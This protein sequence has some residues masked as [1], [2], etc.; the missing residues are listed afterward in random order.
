MS[1]RNTQPLMLAPRGLSDALD[2]STVFSGAMAALENLIPDPSTRNLWQCRPAA[3]QLV[4]FNSVGGPFSSGFSS[5]FATGLFVSPVGAVSVMKVVGNFAYGMVASATG[6]DEPFAFNL[7][8]HTFAVVS[9]T[10]ASN[11]PTSPPPTGA[12]VPP[13]M[14]LIGTKIMV[15][16]PGFNGSVNGF[17]GMLDISV[18][19]TPVWSSG[20]LTGAVTF[21]IPPTAVANFNGRA[22]WIENG[23]Q[24]GLIFSDQLAPTVVTLANQVLTFD[25]NVPLTALAGLGVGMEV[26]GAVLQ[27]LIVFKGASAMYQ[28]TGDAAEQL[29]STLTKNAL[30]VPIGTL[31]PNTI[32][33][34]SKGLMFAAPDGLRMID[35]QS[36]VSDPI[37]VDGMG[38]VL[39]FIYSNVP[40]RMCAAANG[41]VYRITMQDSSISGSPFVEYWYD[42]PRQ[43]WS[44]PHSFPAN[45]IAAWQNT[46]II[47]PLNRPGTLFQSDYVQNSASTFTENSVPLQFRWTTCMLPDTDQMTENAMI[48]T[49]LHAALAGGSTYAVS[50][51]N[52]D[53]KVLQSV[54][55]NITG[56]PTLWGQFVWGQA[57]W[58][59]AAFGLYPR[60]IP[61]PGPVVFRRMQITA[62]GPC[63]AALRIG[64]LH[65][66]YEKLGYLQQQA[67]A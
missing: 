10:T 29:A 38:K 30:N 45:S 63:A 8:S 57:L 31:G 27:S 5:G 64:R 54:I 65:M 19:A 18:P 32:V 33:P 59:G 22:W 13:T 48:E 20:N 47:G 51:L 14:A 34:T 58:G 50:A 12:W 61:W 7:V 67:A 4:D 55:I 37:G 35:F 53:G 17:F 60:S 42:I 16:H 3:Q 52:Q 62:S 9:G 24:P 15:T 46:F 11:V 39:P 43:V 21:S 49:T 28:I 1:L 41:S 56:A 26:T 23:I 6:V 25:D 66:L 2:S 40:S 44:G 36:N